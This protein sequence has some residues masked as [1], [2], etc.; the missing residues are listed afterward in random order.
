M[1][2]SLN[3]RGQSLKNYPTKNCPFHYAS[4]SKYDSIDLD[5]IKFKST[6]IKNRTQKINQKLNYIS[7][8]TNLKVKIKK[9]TSFSLLFLEILN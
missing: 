3:Y 2:S 6:A 8:F 9:T 4:K 5:E 7:D 1:T